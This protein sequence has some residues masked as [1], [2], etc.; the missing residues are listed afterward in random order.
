MRLIAGMEQ[1]SIERMMWIWRGRQIRS[2][3]AVTFSSRFQARS[4]ELALLLVEYFD[5]VGK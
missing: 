4:F 3:E 1:G 5:G 2:V